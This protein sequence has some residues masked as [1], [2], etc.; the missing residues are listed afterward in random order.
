M[1]RPLISVITVSFNA[2]AYL[3]QTINSVLSQT[4]P[5]LEYL[6]IDGGSTDGTVEIIREYASRLAYWHSRPDRGLAHA[7]NLGQAQARGDWLIFLN[8]DDFFLDSAVL[9]NMSP[10][11]AAHQEEDVVFGQT[12]IMTNETE[13]RPSPLIQIL[14]W[15]WHWRK[16]RHLNTIP[17]PSAF[18]NRR[19][20]DRVG[21]FDEGFKIV[22]DY[23]LYLRGNKN[24]RAHYVPLPVSGMRDGG[25]SRKSLIQ[26]LREGRRA[27]EKNQAL[28]W[29]RSWLN[30]FCLTGWFI[31]GKLGHKVLDPL[32]G[33]ISWPGRNSRS[34]LS[35]SG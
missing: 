35:S 17:H 33:K 9:E 4:Y 8:A 13:P 29:A 2:A 32:A 10:Q 5:H 18:T 22:M 28:T 25:V 11:L 23:E 26:N 34:S 21:G 31:L 6:I 7:F 30:L 1:S 3:E 12:V 19:F 15:P 20:F 27:Q 24:L 14:G 16:F